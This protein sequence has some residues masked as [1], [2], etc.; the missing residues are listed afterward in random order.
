MGFISPLFLLTSLAVMLPV[1]FHLIQSR[2]FEEKE[3]ATLH[4]LKPVIQQRKGWRQVTHWPLLLMRM[5]AVLLLAFL[6]ARPFLTSP[7]EVREAE[8]VTIAVDASGSMARRGGAVEKAIAAA[9]EAAPEGSTVRMLQFADEVLPVP[10]GSVVKALPGAETRYDRLVQ[11]ALDH[12]AGEAGRPARIEI[13]SD[14]TRSAVG[15]LSARLWPAGMEV[16]LRLVGSLEDWNAGITGLR[17][18]TPLATTHVEVEAE[19]GFS[20]PVP[21]DDFRIELATEDGVNDSKTVPSGT[22]RVRFKWPLKS[23]PEGAMVRGT[24]R[25][26]QS[27][28]KEDVLAWDDERAFAFPVKKQKSVLLVDGDP[29]DSAFTSETY[30]A[31]KALRAVSGSEGTL[32]PFVPVIRPRMGALDGFDA[33]VLA[34]VAE[35]SPGETQQLAAFVKAGG[36]LMIT[37]GDRMGEG[38]LAALRKEGLEVGTFSPETV[39]AGEEVRSTEVPGNRLAAFDVDWA[40][41]GMVRTWRLTPAPGSVVWLTGAGGN[42]LLTTQ[43]G[44]GGGRVLM[45]AHPLDSAGND[46]PRHPLYL[47]LLRE[48]VGWLTH[49]QMHEASLPGRPATISRILVPGVY[50]EGKDLVE[51]E[52]DPSESDVTGLPEAEVRAALGLGESTAPAALSAEI[53]PGAPLLRQRPAELWPWLA[54]ALFLWLCLES[55]VAAITTS[56]PVPKPST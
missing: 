55:I 28:E 31:D 15:K 39:P 22:S 23:G 35:L 45:L 37:A 12:A 26:S 10:E 24:I 51:I 46:F 18:L 41:A 13:V 21:E 50:Q 40:G 49:F 52:S 5:A 11:W 36:G 9:K 54:G 4:F 42:P 53:P 48:A 25:L 38:L 44:P 16:R 34:N 1:V 20:G 14:F 8:A 6:G 47:V 27:Q 7:Q 30:F 29:A 43:E 17:C 56:L 3:L 2:K 33:I 19:L 32:S